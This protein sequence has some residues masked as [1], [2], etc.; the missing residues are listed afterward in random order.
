[1]ETCTE[2]HARIELDDNFVSCRLV[3]MP[4]R[5]D[6]HAASDAMDAVVRL[7]GVGPVFFLPFGNI[8]FADRAE[9]AEM[10]E[11]SANLLDRLR[12]NVGRVEEGPYH[13]W[14]GRIDGEI[15]TV[16]VLSKRL[17][18]GDTLIEAV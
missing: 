1:M 14:P 17:L 8:E 15:V 18:D 11:R 13:D 10:P 6:Q 4:G 5:L 12:R 9:P 3:I 16:R 7:P 2:R